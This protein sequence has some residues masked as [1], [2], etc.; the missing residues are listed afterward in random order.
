MVVIFTVSS[1]ASVIEFDAVIGR[2]VVDVVLVVAKVVGQ[3]SVAVMG[4]S[5]DPGK[6]TGVFLSLKMCDGLMLRHQQQ[7]R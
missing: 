6:S 3:H 2:P 7:S 1:T 5:T 4:S